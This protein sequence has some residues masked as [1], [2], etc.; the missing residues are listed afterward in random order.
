[1]PTLYAAA[2][3]PVGAADAAPV[4]AAALWPA[5][6][7]EGGLVLVDELWHAPASS[8]SAMASRR[9]AGRGTEGAAGD[10][11]GRCVTEA[12]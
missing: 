2:G 4:G 1:M 10:F 7:S 5:A 8:D 9:V 11:D 12:S 3:A 6:F